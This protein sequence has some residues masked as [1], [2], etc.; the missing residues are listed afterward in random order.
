MSY[1]LFRKQVNLD[2]SASSQ[3]LAQQLKHLPWFMWLDSNHPAQ[4]GR[5]DIVTALPI[6]T[7]IA[8]PDQCCINDEPVAGAPFSLIQQL[9]TAYRPEPFADAP[10][11]GGALGYISYDAGFP[12]Q[13]LP[14]FYAKDIGIPLLAIGLYDWAIVVDHQLKQT[15]LF[16][17]GLGPKAQERFETIM[18]CLQNK[19]AA[20]ADFRLTSDIQSNM[21]QE[22]YTQQFMRIKEH[23]LAGDCY[24]INFAQRFSASYEGDLFA[25]Y[26]KLRGIS[27]APYGGFFSFPQGAILSVSPERFIQVR[28]RVVVTEPI[29]GTRPRDKD[30]LVDQENAQVLRDSLKDQAENV[31]IVDLLRNDLG[32]VCE[33]GS[34]KV[35]E[36][37]ALKSF[38]NVHHLVSTIEG[39]LLADYDAIDLLQASFP[40]GSITGAPKRRAMEIISQLEPHGRSIYCGSLVYIGFDGNIDSNIA[41]RT[42]VANGSELFVW[43]GGGIVADSTAEGEYQETWAKV[44][45]ILRGLGG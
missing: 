9:L 44:R 29:K 17:H 8:W 23:I 1:S 18:A 39:R 42:V 13:E 2:Y 45:N 10:F 36:L 12:L 35:R 25:C 24:Q 15:Q 40:G 30:P 20:N 3:D 31:M 21:S 33:P 27:P 11:T 41:I 22:E 34:V 37:F 32:R 43:G 28:D 16:F 4:E 7:L 19:P 14:D 5:Y 38:S 26:L 6:T